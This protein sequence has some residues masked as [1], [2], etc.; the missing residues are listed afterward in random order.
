MRYALA[1]GVAF[2][3]ACDAPPAATD[4]D[5]AADSDTAAADTDPVDTDR[6]DTDALADTDATDTARPTHRG[7][8]FEGP[9]EDT[10]DTAHDSAPTWYDTGIHAFLYVD[11]SVSD[12]QARLRTSADARA[13]FSTLGWRSR[14][15][16]L[17]LRDPD[18]VPGRPD[19]ELI[20]YLGDS[21]S[22]ATQGLPGV[23]RTAALAVP[24]TW[25][26]RWTTDNSRLE[27]WAWHA[28]AW[29][30]QPLPDHLRAVPTTDA[31]AVELQIPFTLLGCDPASTATWMLVD[32]STGA[33][34]SASP[35]ES[36]VEGLDA[37]VGCAFTFDPHLGHALTYLLGQCGQT[38]RPDGA[39]DTSTP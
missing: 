12:W 22:H 23:T 24:A 8:C 38:R 6:V 26:V 2:V 19:L 31:P 21:H 10:G 9:G 15:L 5:V 30:A 11:G 4:T 16:F 39:L 7:W 3:A 1:L 33:T 34:T 35:S 18:L 37:D 27:L 36:L 32:R 29:H 17:G 25:A 20:A 28:G 14:S 13:V